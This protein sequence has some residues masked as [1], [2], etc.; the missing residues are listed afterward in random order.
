ML[1][2]LLSM[3]D[4][5]LT[6][7]YVTGFGMFEANPIVVRVIG[8]GSPLAMATWKMFTLGVTMLI[9]FAY[10]RRWQA[11]VGTLLC[12]GVMSAL[13]VHWQAYIADVGAMTNEMTVLGHEAAKQSHPAGTGEGVI[14]DVDGARWVSIGY[15]SDGPT[16]R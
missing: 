15:R 5:A 9:L 16:G 11:E 12:V 13:L 10:R 2:W 1:L 8:S 6:L 3:T 14:A 4:L 7:T